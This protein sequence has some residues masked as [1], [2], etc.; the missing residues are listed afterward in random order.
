MKNTVKQLIL[1][2]IIF[3]VLSQVNFV[4]PFQQ[5]DYKEIDRYARNTPKW[6]EETIDDLVRYITRYT[7][8][9]FEKARAIYAWITHNISYDIEGY[10]TKEYGDLTPRGVLMNRST[11]CD[12]YYRKSGEC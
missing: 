6:A 5:T 9:D 10:K 4:Y 12:G 11:I 8:N 1:V 2:S 7:K 3:L